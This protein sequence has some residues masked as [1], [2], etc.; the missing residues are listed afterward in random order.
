MSVLTIRIK[1]NHDG[2]AVLSC[3]RADGSVTWQKQKGSNAS[4]FPQHDLTHYSIISAICAFFAMKFKIQS[5]KF[6]ASFGFCALTF[7]FPA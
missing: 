4:F 6:N 2:T 5:S 7:G 1:K 3:T